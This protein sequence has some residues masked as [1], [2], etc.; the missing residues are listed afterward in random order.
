MHESEMICQPSQKSEGGRKMPRLAR[1][2]S[3][4][5]QTWAAG[6]LQDRHTHTRS[7]SSVKSVIVVLN[8]R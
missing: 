1:A 7:G 6:L 8:L 4:F 3:L 5:A 2:Y